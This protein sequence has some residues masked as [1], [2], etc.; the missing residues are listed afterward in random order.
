MTMVN[1][2]EEH[3]RLLS[4]LYYV[5][6]G[7]TALGAC[8][9]GVYALV[10]GGI[11]T[12]VSQTEQN[13]P[14][15]WIGPMVFILMGAVFLLVAVIAGLTLWTGHSLARRQNYMLCMV[16]AVITCLS[17]PLGTALGVFTLIVLSRA[18]VKQLFG[19]ATPVP[20]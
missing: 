9:T 20:A 7:L 8:F 6:G 13:G 12:A 17:V 4:I 2:D 16:V 5:W 3:L 10:G 15:A 11:L 1:Q 19:R 18:S 14:P